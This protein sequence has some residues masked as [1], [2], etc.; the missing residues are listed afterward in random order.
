MDAPK[1]NVPITNIVKTIIVELHTDGNVSTRFANC[2]KMDAVGLLEIAKNSILNPQQE[3]QSLIAL[4][5]P[6]PNGR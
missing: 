6:R 5:F 2:S 4:P 3:K 1:T